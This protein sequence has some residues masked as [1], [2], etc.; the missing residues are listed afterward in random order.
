MSMAELEQGLQLIESSE[1]ADFV[2]PRSEALLEKA[3]KALGVSFPP[4]YRRFVKEFGYGDMAGAEFCGLVDDNFERSSV[5]NGIWLTLYERKSVSLPNSLILVAETGDGG[6]YAI[7]TTM[8][9]AQGE[10]P[11]VLWHSGL[12]K[13]GGGKPEIVAKDFGAFLLQ[14]ISEAL[15]A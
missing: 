10:S 7:D 8:R 9:D 3:E 6:Y 13:K 14:R 15:E 12:T 5:P 2:G 1:D 11:I 4:T